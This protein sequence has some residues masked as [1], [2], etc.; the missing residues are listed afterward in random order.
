M[1]VAPFHTDGHGINDANGQR[2]C[3]VSSCE[4]YT[5]ENDLPKR[6]PEFD[7]LSSLFA[8]APELLYALKRAFAVISQH[9]EGECCTKDIETIKAA[10]AKA[11][12]K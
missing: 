9:H 6:N 5:Y 3:K 8:A 1:Y 4:P 11:K 2:I 12:G 10:I 7:E